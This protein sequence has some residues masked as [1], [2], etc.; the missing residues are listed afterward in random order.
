MLPQW[1]QHCQRGGRVVL[2]D[3]H[4]RLAE[5]KFILPGQLRRCGHLALSNQNQ[6]LHGSNF[7]QP[8]GKVLLAH[9]LFSLGQ[10][11]R[12]AIQLP[13]GQFQAGQ[14]DFADDE[15][16]NQQVELPRQLQA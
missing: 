9:S 14:E 1:F 8:P 15:T 2:G 12:R 16:V 4:A 10:Q 13:S 3:E 7:R 5:R 6:H 11:R